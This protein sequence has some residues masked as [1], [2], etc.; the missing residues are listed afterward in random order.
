MPFIWSKLQ[1]SKNHCENTD[2]SLST[3][4]ICLGWPD[5]SGSKLQFYQKYSDLALRKCEES[6]HFAVAKHT[7]TEERPTDRALQS[8]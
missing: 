2:C 7:S 4:K 1:H 6:K 3:S 8:L 5:V